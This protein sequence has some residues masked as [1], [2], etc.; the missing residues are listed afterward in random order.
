M[1]IVEDGF[2]PH[3]ASRGMPFTSPPPHLIAAGDILEQVSV[4]PRWF[5]G[6][7]RKE[8]GLSVLFPTPDLFLLEFTKG[9]FYSSQ[10]SLRFGMDSFHRHSPA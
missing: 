5:P 10:I 6:C 3:L 2:S 1:M 7:T 8:K 9:D 4:G